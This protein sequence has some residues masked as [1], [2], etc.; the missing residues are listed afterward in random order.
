MNDHNSIH[1]NADNSKPVLFL[2]TIPPA[3]QWFRIPQKVH[4]IN[5]YTI[6]DGCKH[7]YTNCDAIPHSKSKNIM[8]PYEVSY[9]NLFINGVLQPI[10]NYIV[11]KGKLTLKTVDVPIKNA[12]IILQMLLL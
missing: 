1:N 11:E 5:F 9:M 12:P 10:E 7:V 6:S 4:V 2:P 8:D 3:I